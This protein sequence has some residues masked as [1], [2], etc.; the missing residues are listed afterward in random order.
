MTVNGQRKEWK[1]GLTVAALL[2]RENYRPGRVAV[3]RNGRIMPTGGIFRDSAVGGG[4]P[5]SCEFC[6]RRLKMDHQL[7]LKELKEALCLRHSPE[8]QGKLDGARVAVAGLGGLG[9]NV[10]LCSGQNRRGPSASH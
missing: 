8:V 9:S 6:G 3:E 5:G 1:E 2:E 7:T 10:A 4:C